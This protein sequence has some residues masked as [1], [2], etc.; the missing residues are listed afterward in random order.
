MQNEKQQMIKCSFNYGKKKNLSFMIDKTSSLYSLKGK[1][2]KLIYPIKQIRIFYKEKLLTEEDDNLSI[3]SYFKN[4]MFIQLRIVEIKSLEEANSINLSSVN[5]SNL[6]ILNKNLTKAKFKLSSSKKMQ[7]ISAISEKKP[8]CRCNQ[9][10][11]DV[12]CRDC[13]AFNCFNCLEEE[14]TCFN[15]NILNF[16]NNL[17][18]TLLNYINLVDKNVEIALKNIQEVKSNLQQ[19]KL[20][21][22]IKEFKSDLIE[23]LHTFFDLSINYIKNNFLEKES[24]SASASSSSFNILSL[25]VKGKEALLKQIKEDNLILKS[26]IKI[27][28]FYQ[29]ENLFTKI[30]LADKNLSL[31]L[32]TLKKYKEKLFVAEKLNSIFQNINTS[33]D[34]ALLFNQKEP[35]NNSFFINSN[36]NKDNDKDNDKDLNSEL[37]NKNT[38]N[39]NSEI[40]FSDLKKN[41]IIKIKT[42]K[43]KNLSRQDLPNIFMFQ[44]AKVNFDKN[45]KNFETI[46]DFSETLNIKNST[47]KENFTKISIE[48]YKNAKAK[49][50]A[51]SYDLENFFKEKSSFSNLN[52]ETVEKNSELENNNNNTFDKP[53]NNFKLLNKSNVF[54]KQSDHT[55][56]LNLKSKRPKIEG[57]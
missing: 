38:L 9:N 54:I 30:N 17:D 24:F 34:V 7:T 47:F 31:M 51:V 6:N 11:I 40:K 5:N 44:N 41:K 12:F 14:N 36:D 3:E 39:L 25:T 20:V 23:K 46:K 55:N 33:L 52:N 56:L 16:N 27:L 57:Y 28:S 45:L 26:Q 29:A 53:S 13:N 37:S 8:M 10:Q 22:L 50:L 35:F 4:L 42:N 1:I 2:F 48:N 15:H 49:K 18:L 21:F 32:E 43:A 19:N